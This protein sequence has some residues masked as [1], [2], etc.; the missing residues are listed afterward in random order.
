MVDIGAIGGDTQVRPHAINSSGQVVGFSM[1]PAPWAV[2]AFSWT[3]AGGLIDIGTLGGKGVRTVANDVSDGG[4]VVGISGG[5]RGEHPGPHAF[6]WTP[7]GGMVDLGTLG[8]SESEATAINEQRQI[9]GYSWT[10]AGQKHAFFWSP[11]TGMID[12]G[13]LG[14]HYTEAS[15]INDRG[16]VTGFSQTPA[17]DSHAFSW[18]QAGGMVDLG[19]LGGGRSASFG[20][21]A[22]GQIVGCSTTASGAWH[23]FVWQGGRMMDLGLLGGSGACAYAINDSGQIVGWSDTV[24]DGRAHAVLWS[25]AVAK[26]VIGA[27]SPSPATPVAGKRFTVSFKVRRGDTGKPLTSG[28]MACD[29]SSGGKVLRHTESFKSGIARVSLAIPKSAKGKQLKVKLTITYEGQS[30]TKVS[31]FRIR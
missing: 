14:G 23:A 9:A 4:E 25:P 8:G 22:S 18:T 26:P 5:G 6:S 10:S 28:T 15:E 24:S 7:S 16:Q 19:T 17:G 1:A 31:S 3:Q 30:T 21:N 13:T 11:S 12:I 2:H 29:P 27:P 20:I